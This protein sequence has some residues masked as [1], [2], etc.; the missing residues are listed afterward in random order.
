MKQKWGR[1]DDAGDFPSDRAAWTIA[2]FFVALLSVLAI[3]SY[4]YVRVWTPLQRYYL[5]A[6]V[7]TPVAG[8]IRKDGSYTLLMVVTRKGTR[9]ALDNEVEPFITDKG[10]STFT[11]TQVAMKTG[12]LKLEWQ[13]ARYN[14]AQLHEFL[15]HWIYQDQTLNDL[16]KPALWGGLGVLLV[17][18]VVAI[19]K[20]AARKRIRKHGR[21]LKGPELVTARVFNRRHRW[22]GI[23]FLQQQSRTQKMLG[24]ETWLRLPREMESSHFLI[25]GDTG[26]GK[27]AMIRQILLQVEERGET[28]I[29]YDP[30]SPAD[31]TPY[32]FTPSRGDLILNPL[33]R[34]M[35]YWTPGDELRQGADALTLAASLFPDR[36]SENPFF[37][38]A[39]RKIF[40]HLL[41]FHPTPQELVQWMS[42]PGEIDRRVKGTEYAA[43]I[44][45]ESPP[46]RN[47]VLG[48]L[49]MVADAMKLLPNEAET[50]Q[51]WSTLDW[52]KER[53]GWLFLT[54]TPD[55]RKRLAPLISLW[56]DIL[57]LRLMN[58]GRMSPRPV[59]FI[60]DELATLQRLPQLHTAI[61][62]NRKSNNPV[63]LGF[64]GRSQLEVRY[65][66]EAEAMMSQPSTKIFL[67]TS[68]PHAAKWISDTIGEQEIERVRESRTSG[69]F[70]QSRK[71]TSQNLEREIRPLVMAS[72]ISGL[73]KL[74]GY[75]KCGNLVV[76][77]SLPYIELESREPQYIERPAL[78]PPEPAKVAAATVGAGK[79]L[80]NGTSSFEPMSGTRLLCQTFSRKASLRVRR[81]SNSFRVRTV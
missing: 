60:L 57:V 28:A 22:D 70:P 71:S 9:M 65:G 17:G 50:K 27:S 68:E 7:G 44:D 2:T 26:K 80:G 20:D 56:L 61:T 49:N 42:H 25:V 78:P 63:V 41:S 14:N 5:S 53:R 51:S 24:T 30:A 55:T 46:Q 16:A 72:E 6:Y 79:P 29:V 54:S 1:P 35:P 66:H 34:R 58:Q 67:C 32:F 3:A 11:L 13:R 21:R 43:M 69:Q 64:Q 62:E 47:G 18:L 19:P 59:W 52:S 74:H 15:G 38:E 45:R 10:E 12:D 36:H 39:P 31:Y 76:R 8:A 48:S 77:M 73:E 81:K 23:G 75:L 4:N 37:V 33:D 40:A